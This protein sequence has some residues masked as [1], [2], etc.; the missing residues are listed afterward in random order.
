MKRLIYIFGI[1][2]CIVFTLNS[3]TR[4]WLE[5]KRDQS[6]IVPS[7]LRDLGLLLN[8]ASTQSKD[9]IALSEISTDDYFLTSQ[10][11]QSL[12]TPAE[13]NGYLWKKDVF[14][15]TIDVADWDK[16]YKQVMTANVIIEAL[17][18][19]SKEIANEI[20]WNRV[21][22]EALALRGK[23]FYNLA[24][25]FTKAYDA[26]TAATDLGIP[27]RMEPDVNL[28]TTRASLKE[29]YD[30]ILNDL[31]TASVLLPSLPDQKLKA[32]KASVF[33]LLSR[34]YLS[35]RDYENALLFAEKSLA[36]QNTLIDYNTL[37]ITL[38]FPFS[39]FNTE[40]IQ[41]C[42]ID[43]TYSVFIYVFQNYVDTTLYESYHANDLRK[44]LFFYDLGNGRYSYKGAYSGDVPPFSG[45]AV[46]ELMLIRAECYARKNDPNLAMSILNNLLQKRFKANTFIP[47]TAANSEDALRI[48]LSERRKELIKRGIRWSDLKRLNKEPAHAKTLIRILAGETYT[49]PPNDPRYVMPIPEYVIKVT[50]IQ[51]NI[52]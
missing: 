24:Q 15:Q 4:E 36:I 22:G 39:R 14:D 5:V 13:R 31:N 12:A 42:Q 29:T 35:M 38:L 27:L 44:R 23:A 45:V 28:P 30:R 9:Y 48:I 37:D 7:T 2:L 10:N 41:H 19:I 17:N 21:M 20:E 46:D 40:V 6:I 51:Q 8:D 3:C 11:W 52:R 33:G 26:T 47:L 49:L 25:L 43:H 1:L 50:G 32:S 16:S 18:K 34:C